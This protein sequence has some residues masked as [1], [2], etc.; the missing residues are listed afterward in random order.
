MCKNPRK[1]ECT[2]YLRTWT[3][4]RVAD[5]REQTGEWPE[6]RW[7]RAYGKDAGLYPNRTGKPLEVFNRNWYGKICTLWSLM[8]LWRGTERKWRP[9]WEIEWEEER[10]WEHTTLCRLGG[11][12]VEIKSMG[13]EPNRPAWC[14]GFATYSMSLSKLPK[15]CFLISKMGYYLST[16][17]VV[18]GLND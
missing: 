17:W 4:T 5:C 9:T 1:G 14:P 16:S 7:E 12:T 13:S 15:L 6:M 2:E 8:V 10:K 11:N 3:K 18:W